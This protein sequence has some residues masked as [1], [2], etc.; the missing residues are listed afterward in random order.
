VLSAMRITV[1]E[2]LKEIGVYLVYSVVEGVTVAQNGYFRREFE[3]L[4]AAIKREG[5]TKVN[6]VAQAYRRFYWKIGLDPT[7]T[8]P[9]GEA[10]RRRVLNGGNIP[11][12]NT[13]VDAANL[14]SAKTLVPIGL[15]DTQTLSGVLVLKPSTGGER[16]LAIGSNIEELLP[17][18]VPILV[19]QA[20]PLR[21]I[22]LYP[23]RDSQHTKITPNTKNVLVVG[24]GVEGVDRQYVRL[25]IEE[26]LL[27]IVESS[28]GRV[29]QEPAYA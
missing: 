4:E 21:A 25:A 19:D 5:D 17:K 14:V 24:A 8:R 26:V 11:E 27:K 23:H 6:A 10:L 22:H 13:V 1:C 16:F 12:I 18:G 9:A 3:Q 15:Y 20:D 2:P 29:L 7:K 28:G